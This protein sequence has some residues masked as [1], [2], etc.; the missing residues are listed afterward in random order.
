MK[1][2]S[3]KF[4]P[5][6]ILCIT[7]LSMAGMFVVM[8]L[9]V[10]VIFP[11]FGKSADRASDY[12][13]TVEVR[14]VSGDNLTAIINRTSFPTENGNTFNMREVVRIARGLNGWNEGALPT[15]HP[16]DVVTVQMYCGEGCDEY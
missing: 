2:N 7:A 15:I 12:C 5:I 8:A 4:N 11:V 16:N 13:C 3:N 14:V 6:S 10:W 9:L 1:A